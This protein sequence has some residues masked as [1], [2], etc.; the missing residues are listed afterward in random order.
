MMG[1]YV[2]TSSEGSMT[3]VNIHIA[4]FNKVINVD[5]A[6]GLGQQ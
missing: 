2:M 1:V 5:D 3:T 4:G 6:S